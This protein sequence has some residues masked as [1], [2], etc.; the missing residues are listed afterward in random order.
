MSANIPG[1]SPAER[2]DR[3]I[4]L[5]AKVATFTERRNREDMPGGLEED[6]AGVAVEPNR[7]KQ[8]NF[9]NRDPCPKI[10]EERRKS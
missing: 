7:N 2:V 8:E 6:K 4:V 3:R 1:N 10:N 5:P 9:K